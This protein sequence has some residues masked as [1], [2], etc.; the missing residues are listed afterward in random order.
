MSHRSDL[1]QRERMM[2][3]LKI[4]VYIFIVCI[5]LS[6]KLYAEEKECDY[7]DIDE[8]IACF[9]DKQKQ[10]KVRLRESSRT[11]YFLCENAGLSDCEKYKN[12]R[13][14]KRSYVAKE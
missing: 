3:N 10:L 13:V 12:I 1:Q 11:L 2:I 8:I 14:L 9:R 6:E 7:K 5:F 4:I